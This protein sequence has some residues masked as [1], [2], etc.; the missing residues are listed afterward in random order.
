MIKCKLWSPSAISSSIEILQNYTLVTNGLCIFAYASGFLKLCHAFFGWGIILGHGAYGWSSSPRR[1]SHCF[2]HFVFM[3]SLSTF[4]FHMNNTSFS[5]L[6]VFFGGYWQENY[7]CMCGHYGSRIMG[8]FSR[9]LTR[10]H[11]QLLISFSGIRLLFTE[12][13]APSTFIGNWA[14]VAPYLCTRF[15]IFDRPILEDYVF[16]IKGGPTHVSIM[17]TY[18]TSWPSSCS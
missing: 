16:Q 11:A 1:C 3:C 10:H 12:D 7:A 9:P 4:L 17:F 6:H 14:L 5:F 8:I 13:C 15:I 2:G 18:N